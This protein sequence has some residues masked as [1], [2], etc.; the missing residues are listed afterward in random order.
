MM[1]I[2]MQSTLRVMSPKLKH[3]LDHYDIKP[4]TVF[5]EPHKDETKEKIRSEKK[6]WYL[7]DF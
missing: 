1:M 4:V 2:I 5:E 6:S 7:W 3:W